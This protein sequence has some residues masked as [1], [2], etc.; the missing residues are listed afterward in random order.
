LNDQVYEKFSDLT[1]VFDGARELCTFQAITSIR[2]PHLLK[3]ELFVRKRKERKGPGNSVHI[4]IEVAD[5]SVS[6]DTMQ[7]ILDWAYT[8]KINFLKLNVTDIM[9]IILA[10]SIVGTPSLALMCEIQLKTELGTHNIFPFLKSAD[11]L[12]LTALKQFA[13]GFSVTNWSSVM[14]NKEG[15]NIIGIDLFQEL[16]LA[17]QRGGEV[18]PYVPDDAPPNTTTDDF[19]RIYEEMPFHDAL[20]DFEA[21]HQTKIPF[22]RAILAACSDKLAAKMFSAKEGKKL[23][24]V[25]FESLTPDAF[26]GLLQV[27]YY[28]ESTMDALSA[29]I[30]LEHFVVPYG[31][32]V[33]RDKCEEIIAAELSVDTVVPIVRITYLKVND[34][35]THLT[36]TLRRRCL[37]Y[38][39]K[40]FTEVDIEPLRCMVPEISSDLLAVIHKR[41]TQNK[42][43][44]L[45]PP[46]GSEDAQFDETSAAEVS[47]TASKRRAA[48]RNPRVNKKV[49]RFSVMDDDG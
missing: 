49:L 42:I 2:I 38:I 46:A 41:F 3:S 39:V 30:L 16:T 7:Q 25:T 33:V 34:G 27:L 11:E 19:R 8:G 31:V 35:R 17:V 47:T 37:S 18:P 10:S 24:R 26:Y 1:L 22:H 15:L 40:H 12:G 6:Y 20:C 9:R 44:G 14:T 21:T 29:C 45:A 4:T 48:T 32:T 23:P 36:D 28:G 13:I 5:N 43:D